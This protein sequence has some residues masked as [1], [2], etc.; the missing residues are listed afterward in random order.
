MAQ[1]SNEILDLLTRTLAGNRLAETRLFQHL[2]PAIREGVVCALFLANV[3]GLYGWR[4]ADD[5][6]DLTQE[7]HAEL[8]KNDKSALRNFDPTRDSGNLDAYVCRIAKHVTIARLRV[9]K[10]G[11]METPTSPDEMPDLPHHDTNPEIT[12]MNRELVQ[13]VL[14]ELDLDPEEEELFHLH[15]VDELDGPS[16]CSLLEEQ[17]RTRTTTLTAL[18]KWTSRIREKCRHILAKPG[19]NGGSK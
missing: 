18:W 7:T 13:V 5:V 9:L 15:F 16:I 12:L 3:R 6:D 10:R 4:G 17:Q 11:R 19:R 8:L 1:S 2:A 14:A